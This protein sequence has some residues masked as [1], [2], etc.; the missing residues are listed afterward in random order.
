MLELRYHVPR[1]Q[2]WAGSRG[3]QAGNVH[4]HT[5]GRFDVGRLHRA[6]GQALCGRS[7]WYER[8][9]DRGELEALLVSFIRGGAE[10][11][12]GLC[13]RCAE[14]A[15]RVSA[16]AVAAAIEEAVGEWRRRADAN[17]GLLAAQS[18]TFRAG[19]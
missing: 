16:G 2:V 10:D 14:I 3:R 13:S 8:A 18:G 11:A 5:V 6:A 17:A 15:R 19:E 9:P 12:D 7:G 4:L 1:S